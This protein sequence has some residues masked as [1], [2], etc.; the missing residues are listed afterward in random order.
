MRGNITGSEFPGTPKLLKGALAVYPSNTPGP[1]PKIVVFQYNPEQ[2]RR[3]L[4]TRTPPKQ[5]GESAPAKEDVLRTIGPPVE[6]INLSIVLDAADQLSNPD[7]NKTT[8]E[9]GLHPALATLELLLYPPKDQ[10]DELRQASERGEVQTNPP[11]LP[12]TLLVWGKSRVVPVILTS[13]SVAEEAFDPKL[14]PIR[15]RIEL[16]MRVLS[17]IELPA[18]TVGDNAFMAY[19]GQKEEL[20]KKHQSGSGD[21]QRSL[22]PM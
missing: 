3:T 12:L 22:L 9:H 15:A 4:A 11:D 20:A 14:N 6:T 18:S 19:Q 2:M 5:P 21:E 1:Q 17:Y 8:V 7:G 16:G 13:F 10:V